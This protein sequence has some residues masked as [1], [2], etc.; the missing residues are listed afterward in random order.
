MNHSK[1]ELK[2]IAHVPC[3]L[4]GPAEGALEGPGGA[5][6]GPACALEGPGGA[7]EGPAC[8]LE[9][10]ACA[11]EGPAEGALEGPAS[12]GLGRTSVHTHSTYQQSALVGTKWYE[13]GLYIML[14]Q[15]LEMWYIHTGYASLPSEI[16]TCSINF[17]L[18]TWYLLSGSKDN[19]GATLPM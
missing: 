18:N 8:A 12:E 5:L 16:G 11:L 19:F 6:E 2:H 13:V 3:A 14:Q 7:L 1:Q 4:E 17:R 10:P 9:G 15:R